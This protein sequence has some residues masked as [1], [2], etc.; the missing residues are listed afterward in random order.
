MVYGWLCLPKSLA[1][2]RCWSVVGSLISGPP[3]FRDCWEF[4]HKSI[5]PLASSPRC[6][7]WHLVVEFSSW[8]K[9]SLP[10]W[11]PLSSW[12]P[13]ATWLPESRDELAH[14]NPRERSK[15]QHAGELTSI[16][17]DSVESPLRC[18]SMKSH[19]RCGSSE[20]SVFNSFP[21]VWGS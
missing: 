17:S 6:L 3:F 15:L 10:F 21:S 5:S 16:Q 8:P 14:K 13:T 11:H 18:S 12:D 4:L 2:W 20:L 19:F 9:F 7:S 1:S